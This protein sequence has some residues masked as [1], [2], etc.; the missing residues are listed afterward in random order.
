MTIKKND[1]QGITNQL[2]IKISRL[3]FC[4]G[5]VLGLILTAFLWLNISTQAYSI[6]NWISYAGVLC[7]GIYLLFRSSYRRIYHL[8]V[9]FSSVAIIYLFPELFGPACNGLPK[10]FASPN[11]ICETVC[12]EVCTRWV[13]GPSAACPFPGPGGGCCL[14]YETKCK[15][16]CTGGG[17]LPP[18]ISASLT[19]AQWGSNG[20]CRST[21]QLVLTASDP[22]GYALTITGN[23]GSV[24]ISCSGSCTVNLPTGSGVA[25]YI[26]SAATSGMSVSGSTPWYYDPTA[27]LSGV[28]VSG[29]SGTNNW[30]TSAVTASVNSSDAISGIASAVIAVDGGAAVASAILIDGVHSVTA[31]VIDLAGNSSSKTTVISVDTLAPTIT[32]SALGNKTPDGWFSTPVNLS[33]AAFDATSGVAGSVAMSFDNGATWVNGLQTLND[34]IYTVIFRAVDRAGNISTTQTSLKIDTQSPSIVLS[35]NGMLGLNGWY[36]SDVILS[37]DV[38]DNLSG[39]KLIQ[40]RVNNGMWQN[41]A[42]VT[43]SEGIHKVDFQ[44]FDMADN[45]QSSSQEIHIDTTMPA[46]NFDETLNG[47]VFANTASLGGTVLDET[48]TVHNVEFSV[49]GTTWQSV[50]FANARWWIE[51]DTTVFENGVRDLYLRVDDMAGNKG[52][53]ISVKI[54]LDNF[55]PY[56]KLTKTWN[57]WESGSLVVLNNVIPLKSVKIVVQDPIQRFADKVIYYDLP[58]PTTITWD[59]VIGPASA[60]PGSYTISVEACDI[61]G[62]CAKE[63]GTILIPFDLTPIPYQAPAI[64]IPDLIQPV[65][66]FTQTPAP[67][68]EQP[69]INSIFI[70]P[71]HAEVNIIRPSTWA[72]V[73]L[74]AFLLSFALLLLMDPRPSALRSL[75][76]SLHQHIQHFKE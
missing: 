12:D 23:A 14:S 41:G 70:V 36:V 37:A 15:Q 52:Q 50:S 76:K 40:Y 29:T 39:V 10:V 64:E 2:K 74:S 56:V 72:V 35:T 67:A 49:D 71:T 61:Y 46:Y 34:G 33:A 68:L 6:L 48:S 32:I 7:S 27:P 3:M 26:V 19:C 8:L 44:S 73:V 24:P 11:L 21:A 17:N 65:P 53:P 58:A 45:A 5:I 66:L 75:T 43:I 18:T 47:D 13:P 54:I 57:I 25:A 30:Y 60:P 51:W 9:L 31:T 55:P 1:E 16:Q 69:I 38:N 4:L 20:W 28:N 63:K 59:R 22:Q 62:L 42:S